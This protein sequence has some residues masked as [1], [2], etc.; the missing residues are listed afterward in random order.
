V[1]QLKVKS[2]N[3]VFRYKGKEVDVQ[4]VGKELTVDALL[5]GRVV[6]R[7]R[8]DHQ[9]DRA[10]ITDLEQLR[11]K[12]A[13]RAEE[14][15]GKMT[16]TRKLGSF[17]DPSWRIYGILWSLCGLRGLQRKAFSYNKRTMDRAMGPF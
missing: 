5:T 6:Q 1:P 9:Q 7:W 10:D 11:A 8:S 14:A 12:F 16:V 13:P 4:K 15:G 17:L 3:S 2:R